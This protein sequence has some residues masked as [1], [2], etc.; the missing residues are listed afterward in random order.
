LTEITK[1]AQEK[2]E[3]IELGANTKSKYGKKA[4]PNYSLS[5]ETIHNNS[6]SKDSLPPI[7]PA[8]KQKIVLFHNRSGISATGSVPPS[9]PSVY[10]PSRGSAKP[11]LAAKPN[12]AAKSIATAKP[13]T[14]PVS[15]KHVPIKEVLTDKPSPAK[16]NT[17]ATRAKRSHR[18]SEIKG[19]TDLNKAIAASKAK[20]ERKK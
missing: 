2:D 7:T 17:T 10:K 12:P 11:I 19:N 3:V 9:L 15:K 18:R 8:P 20:L 14:T 4:R 5:K 16:V 6:D 1:Q 13:K